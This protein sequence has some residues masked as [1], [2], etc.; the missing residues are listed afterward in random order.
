MPILNKSVG[1]KHIILNK[2]TQKKGGSVDSSEASSDP[3]VPQIHRS[4][5]HFNRIVREDASKKFDNSIPVPT[6][7]R[8]GGGA[9]LNE[10]SFRTARRLKKG[11]DDGVNLK[12]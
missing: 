1:Q 4:E 2:P 8:F 7:E 10:L 3:F 11:K 12:I 5:P 9:L 6:N